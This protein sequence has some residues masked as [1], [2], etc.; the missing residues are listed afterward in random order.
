M[1][2]YRYPRSQ[3]LTLC[4]PPT[5]SFFAKT[6]NPGLLSTKM[7]AL[8]FLIKGEPRKTICSSGT[9]RRVKCLCLVLSLGVLGWIWH[10]RVTAILLHVR[11]KLDTQPP[12]MLRQAEPLFLL[13][14][15]SSVPVPGLWSSNDHN[16]RP[17]TN[18]KDYIFTGP[19]WGQA[20]FTSTSHEVTSNCTQL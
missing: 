20:S 13:L 4:T 17:L 15:S 16:K 18:F 7:V 8:A 9:S 14:C 5:G 2:I 10:T 1:I 6:T 19:S 12:S 11:P 3:F